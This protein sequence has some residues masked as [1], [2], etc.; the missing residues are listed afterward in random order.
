MTAASVLGAGWQ[1]D[2][3]DY[4]RILPERLVRI[5][6]EGHRHLGAESVES[7]LHRQCRIGVATFGGLFECRKTGMIRAQTLCHGIPQGREECVS[8]RF[9][10]MRH[11]SAAPSPGQFRQR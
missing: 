1:P 5:G 4:S 11:L 8:C 7:V 9:E 10:H 3:G 6:H 2:C